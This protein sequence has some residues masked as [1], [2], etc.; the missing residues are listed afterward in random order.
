MQMQ[1]TERILMHNTENEMLIEAVL[2]ASGY[3]VTYAKLSDILGLTPS[4]TKKEV[5]AFAKKYN[6]PENKRGIAI[7]TDQTKAGYGILP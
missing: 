5:E 2:F 6:A 7:Q 1:R 4:E 3:P